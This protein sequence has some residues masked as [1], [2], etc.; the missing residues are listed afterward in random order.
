MPTQSIK[1][2]P[3][4]VTLLKVEVFL[5]GGWQLLRGI[6]LWQQADLL[7]PFDVLINL[8]LLG[9]GALIWSGVFLLTA[10]TAQ[11]NRFTLLNQTPLFI[12][13][14]ALYSAIIQ[15]VVNQDLKSAPYWIST[16]ALYILLVSLNFWLK[17][18]M[19]ER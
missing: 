9:T 17:S 16:I 13:F 10:V 6:L 15:W 11:R 18:L 19:K 4:I 3:F 12:L 2:A 8:R 1:K 14:F 7:E 5:I